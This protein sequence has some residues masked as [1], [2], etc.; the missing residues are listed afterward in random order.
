MTYKQFYNQYGAAW[1]GMEGGFSRKREV[2]EADIPDSA[3]EPECVQINYH[4]SQGFKN[5]PRVIPQSQSA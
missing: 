2:F 4:T 5:A 1:G 3:L